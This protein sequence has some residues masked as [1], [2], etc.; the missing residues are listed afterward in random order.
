MKNIRI[1]L[2]A[3]LLVALASLPS[4]AQTPAHSYLP[5]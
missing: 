4:S 1:A 3:V 2:A 5:T